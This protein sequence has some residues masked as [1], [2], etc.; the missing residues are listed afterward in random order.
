MFQLILQLRFLNPSTPGTR[1]FA[2][3]AWYTFRPL[4][5]AHSL[6]LHLNLHLSLSLFFYSSRLCSLQIWCD[7]FSDP[8][9]LTFH[10]NICL[11]IL[12]DLFLSRYGSMHFGPL[13]SRLSS[14]YISL[15]IS[16]FFWIWLSA[17]LLDTFSDPLYLYLLFHLIISNSLSFILTLHPPTYSKVTIKSW[18]KIGRDTMLMSILFVGCISLKIIAAVIKTR[19]LWHV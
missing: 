3:L 17:D 13:S 15:L 6:S 12:L 4:S 1:F 7:T 11:H 19:L 10:L 2:N 16:I 18:N 9:H 14:L 5:S 8:L